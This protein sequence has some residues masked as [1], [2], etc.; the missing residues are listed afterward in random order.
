LKLKYF[1]SL[2]LIVGL[3]PYLLVGQKA[4]LEQ[5]NFNYENGDYNRAIELYNT[6]DRIEE[7]DES[8]LKRG[9]SQYNINSLS[10][11]IV[12]MQKA[13]NLKSKDNRIFLY[14]ALSYHALNNFEEAAI[15]YKNYLKL[16]DDDHKSKE[17]VLIRIKQCESALNL[18]YKESI[19]FVENLGKD[20]NTAK[21][22][23]NPYQSPNNIN[24]FYF[25]S[26]NN[27]ILSTNI[28]GKANNNFDVYSVENRNAK[29]SNI[30]KLDKRINSEED[31]LIQGFNKEG[32]VIFVKK[33]YNELNSVLITDSISSGD[34]NDFLYEFPAPIIYSQGDKDIQEINDS[35]Y[36]FSSKR[37]GGFG[38]YDIYVVYKENNAWTSPVNLGNEINSEYDD[39]SPF[40]TKNG[41]KLYFSSNRIEGFGGYDIFY[42]SFDTSWGIPENIGLPINSSE[43]D[44]EL[45][46]SADGT[47]ALFSSNRKEGYGLYD[48][49]IVYFKEQVIEQMQ[50]YE[51]RLLAAEK[52]FSSSGF[53]QEEQFAER[54]PEIKT[55]EFYNKPLF[56]QEESD[57]LGP[58]N[59]S[60]IKL[61][62]DILKI[63][64]DYQL[65]LTGHTAK[66]ALFEFDL[67]FS[68]KRTELLADYL[69]NQG[70]N[71]QKIK[72][73]G[74]GS[75]YPIAKSNGNQ[76]SSVADKLNKRIDIKIIPGPNS[77]LLVIDEEIP[78]A[79]QFADEKYNDYKKAT[80]GL[81]YKIY[82]TSTNQ[83]FKDPILKQYG[84]ASIE[85][86][87]SEDHYNYTIGLFDNYKEAKKTLNGISQ[88]DYPKA[89]I[90]IYI[91]GLQINNDKLYLYKEKYPDLENYLLYEQSR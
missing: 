3:F 44:L 2:V 63:Y 12:D 71:A 88:L 30:D 33:F 67:Y 54:Q 74:S 90:L 80:K 73:I 32:N 50:Y 16:L 64:P 68:A 47:T 11:C 39:I 79:Y 22:E 83:M 75:S 21:D 27:L 87:V 60:K 8:I 4:I 1:I 51:N 55:K 42:S 91:N 26:N 62:I 82:I 5:A 6:Y 10:S 65:V 29:W 40:L 7:D 66:E 57:I 78:V 46:I 53:S 17:R 70:L 72:T 49:Y 23:R 38:G 37:E 18:K 24:K 31:D 45:N 58:Q 85:K 77:P 41:K 52:V 81:S 36:I 34:S 48:L 19:G 84:G 56:Y 89:K 14:T 28:D 25:S 9:I 43:D 15:F 59:L 76:E 61:L 69:V 35:T 86:S 20:I 13:F